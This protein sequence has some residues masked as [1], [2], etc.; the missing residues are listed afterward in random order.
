MRNIENCMQD[1]FSEISFSNKFMIHKYKMIYDTYDQFKANH[2]L[3][4]EEAKVII[5][6]TS[7]PIKYSYQHTLISTYKRDK[8]V[9]NNETTASKIIVSKNN[10]T[11][12]ESYMIQIKAK[13]LDFDT[14]ILLD[15]INVA[16]S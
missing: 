10:T 12:E 1:V 4:D 11:N 9:A 8:S 5:N 13:K 3:S 7:T 14:D 16:V 6:T 2:E 15:D